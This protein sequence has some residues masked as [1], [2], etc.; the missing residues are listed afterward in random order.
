MDFFV[1]AFFVFDVAP[2]RA[3]LRGDVAAG[4]RLPV[5]ALPLPEVERPVA[6]FARPVVVDFDRA[7]VAVRDEVVRRPAAAPEVRFALLD[8]AFPPLRPAAA[9]FADELRLEAPVE[10][11]LVDF[12]VEPPVDFLDELL[13]ERP[14][15]VA[16]APFLPAALFFAVLDE[17]EP[18]V[19][20]FFVELERELVDFFAPPEDERDELELFFEP[21]LLREPD[22]EREPVDFL[23]VAMRIVPPKNGVLL[24]TQQL[25]KCVPRR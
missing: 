1:E 18:P 22:E 17:R 12:L 14:R 5:V 21:P 6:V 11:L 16:A 8:A 13:D 2:V 4:V 10:R 3:V 23:A 15:F 24:H 25:A 7:D 19:D 20:F 9:F